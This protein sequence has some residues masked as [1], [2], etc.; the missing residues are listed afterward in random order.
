MAFGP[1]HVSDYEVLWESTLISTNRFFHGPTEAKEFMQY[2]LGQNILRAKLLICNKVV[3][4]IER[5]NGQL[6][7]ETEK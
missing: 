5:V 1:P 2:L 7:L 3:S 6:V 4:R